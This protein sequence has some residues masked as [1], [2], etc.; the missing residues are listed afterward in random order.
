VFS[1]HRAK[2]LVFRSSFIFLQTDQKG[3]PDEAIHLQGRR[4]DGARARDRIC[5][6]GANSALPCRTTTRQPGER[7]TT[8][9]R[10]LNHPA[11]ARESKVSQ[12]VAVAPKKAARRRASLGTA[13]MVIAIDP[14]T[15]QLGMPGPGA[16]TP[17]PHLPVER[18][19]LL[20]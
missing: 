1:A 12:A 8:P 20:L 17:V 14:E 4:V 19:Q 3:T 18:S 9:Q 15:G 6:V 7:L 13:S 10:R 2:A 11:S 5:G 16:R